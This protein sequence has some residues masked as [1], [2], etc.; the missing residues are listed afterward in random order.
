VTDPKTVNGDGRAT[1]LPEILFLKIDHRLE[2]ARRDPAF[3][4]WLLPSGFLRTP[5]STLLPLLTRTRPVEHQVSASIERFLPVCGGLPRVP[6]RPTGVFPRRRFPESEITR[7]LRPTPPPNRRSDDA[8]TLQNPRCRAHLD[9][10]RGSLN[11]AP[12]STAVACCRLVSCLRLRLLPLPLLHNSATM[13]T[14]P[15]SWRRLHPP[16]AGR[17]QVVHACAAGRNFWL[18]RLLTALC[19]SS[20]CRTRDRPMSPEPR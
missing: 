6:A 1:H 3:P 5:N 12:P 9:A 8:Q 7:E 4:W 2:Q 18:R 14:T 13:H 16:V 19:S 17:E 11:R 10:L 15:S 20:F